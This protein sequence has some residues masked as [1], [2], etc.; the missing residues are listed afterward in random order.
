MSTETR[1]QWLERAVDAFRPLFAFGTGA[2]YP[3]PAKI[4]VSTGFPFIGR[5][6]IGEC[7]LPSN[8]ADGAHQI[9]ISPTLTDI[10]GPQGVLATLFHELCHAALPDEVKHR[11]AF[12]RLAA[13]VYLVGPWTA[14]SA[15]ESLQ[16]L[17]QQME[18]ELGPSPHAAITASARATKKQTTRLLKAE[19]KCGYTVRVTRKWLDAVG[20]PICPGH[21]GKPMNIKL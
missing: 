4:R 14:T 10:S 20:A 3:L 7:W 21:P 8:S 11:G 2:G 5:K 13:A 12:K 16:R 1:E 19:C 6:S 15:S 9:F 18:A 17:F